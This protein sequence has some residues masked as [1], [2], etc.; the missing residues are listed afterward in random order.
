MVQKIQDQKINNNGNIDKIISIN[1]DK[2]SEAD[3]IADL[4]DLPFESNYFDSFLLL[5]VLEHVKKSR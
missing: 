3:I 4:E 5:E 1:I 2:N